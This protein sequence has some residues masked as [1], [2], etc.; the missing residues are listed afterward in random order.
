[1]ADHTN[2]TSQLHGYAIL[3]SSIH[4]QP[5]YANLTFSGNVYNQVTIGS[6]TGNLAQDVTL[7][8]TTFGF[9][10]ITSNNSVTGFMRYC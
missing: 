4:M 2:T 1:V 6:F 9:T 3:Q 7:A 10:S 8:G 5:S